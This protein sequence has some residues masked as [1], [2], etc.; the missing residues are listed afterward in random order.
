MK[1]TLACLGAAVAMAATLGAADFN[2]RDFGGSVPKAAEAAAKAGGG[3]I[4]VP[5]GRWTS[6]T[7]WLKD[8]CELHLEK[9][10]TIVGSTKPADYNANDVFPENFWSNGEEWSGGHL[11]LAYKATD[12]A[13]TGEG[14]IDGN[15]PA[16]FGEP[17]YDS[18]FPGYKYGLKL[19]PTDRTWY[20]PG[21]M[22]AMFLCKNVRVEGVTLKN[23][24]CWT[25]HI[26][27]S[28]GVVLRGVTIDADRTIANSDGFSIDC[29]R[30]VQVK[31]CKIFT[32]D[33]GFA[34]RASCARHAAT[35]FCENIRIENCDVSSCCFG[36][37]YGIGTGT[38]RNVEVRN[39][40][41]HESCHGI[42]FTPIWTGKGRG[43]HFKNVRHYDCF[44]GECELPVAAWMPDI[45][46]R[47]DDVSFENC[48]FESLQPIGFNGP[49]AKYS[50]LSF[51][52]CERKYLDKIKVRYNLRWHNE[53]PDRSRAFMAP[54]NGVNELVKCVNC[55]P[56][57]SFEGALSLSFDD[58]NFAEWRAAE[59]IFAKYG[60]HATF[61]VSGTI[62][63]EAVATM[64]YLYERGHSV[65]LHGLNHVNSD[66]AIAKHGADK[67]FADDVYPQYERCRVCYVT[68]KSF[69]YP[70][71]RYSEAS[72]KLFRAN[73][74][75]VKRVRGVLPGAAPYDP[76]GVKQKD[77]KPLQTID[78][79]F[80]S[81]AELRK[82]YRIDTAILGEAYHTDLDEV[83]ACLKR[84]KERKEFVSFTS[85]GISPD[86]KHIN[87]KTEWLEKI[88]AYAKEIGLPVVGFDELPPLDK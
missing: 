74:W 71:G 6:G 39:C 26:R 9:G 83:L 31:D 7:I 50:N 8:H 53:H 77:R 82:R 35:N 33:D 3:R 15:G 69:A 23:T 67:Y 21:P 70:N 76:Q 13:I 79:L 68:V 63:N 55:R 80:A 85:H 51:A 25:C 41:F 27:C 72:D 42:G 34:I 16:F 52:N 75:W 29:T 30:N 10:A 37:R 78:A 57:A 14:T 46:V 11:V 65:G 38:I 66:E 24:P 4:V 5:A 17:D 84:A 54:S 28:D 36:I 48:T 44:I 86:A 81:E 59:P 22:V 20:R 40:R 73:G 45:D 56:S 61:F 87:L 18:W 47:C 1:K 58:R 43:V 62:D 60:A 64:K 88:L 49:A 12:V 19:F 2:V 32:G